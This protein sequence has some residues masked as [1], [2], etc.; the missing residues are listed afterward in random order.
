M[1]QSLVNNMNVLFLICDRT[2]F[3]LQTDISCS[4][5]F[6]PIRHHLGNNIAVGQHDALWKSC[7]TAGVDYHQYS[8]WIQT[9]VHSDVSHGS[10]NQL[11]KPQSSF[12]SSGGNDDILKGETKV[13]CIIDRIFLMVTMICCVRFLLSVLLSN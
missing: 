6:L 10:L 2:I 8:I 12:T 9:E 7:R 4:S 1:L 3:P 11:R 5:P 13:I